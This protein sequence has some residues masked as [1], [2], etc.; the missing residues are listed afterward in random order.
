MPSEVTVQETP[1]SAVPLPPHAFVKVRVEVFSPPPPVEIVYVAEAMA[2][3]S[4][5]DLTA[6]ALRVVVEEMVMAPV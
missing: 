2:L 5:P 1:S 6:M 3:S 4:M